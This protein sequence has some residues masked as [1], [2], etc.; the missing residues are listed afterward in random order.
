MRN[1]IIEMEGTFLFNEKVVDFEIS[2]GK[3]VAVICSSGKKVETDSVVLA[4]GHSARDT[5]EK[6]F[7][8][9]VQMV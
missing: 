5:F 7:E 4:I 9:G 2:N 3:V 6:L 8:K 1:K